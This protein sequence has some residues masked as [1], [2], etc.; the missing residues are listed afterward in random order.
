VSRR[1]QIIGVAT[2]LFRERGFHAVGID[3]I[4]SAAGIS[5]PGIY[6]HFA[7]KDDLLVSVF[8][9]AT[10]DLW[11]DLD[12]DERPSVEA[13]VR[14]HVAY[15]LAH[16]DAIE[17]WYQEGRHLPKEARRAQ[18]QLQ[19]RYVDRWVDALCERR[20]EL[21]QDEARIVVQA[22]IGLIHST[23]HSERAV[24]VDELRSA[25]ERMALAALLA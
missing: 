8:E 18:R 17:L 6:R 11:T 2:K 22:V 14:S 19:R 16:A 12:P 25:L 20:P 13:Y 9:D 4:G 21:E 3:E 23:A 5:G 24:D 10:D 7:S 1:A 15:A